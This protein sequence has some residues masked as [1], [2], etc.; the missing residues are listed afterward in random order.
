MKEKKFDLSKKRNRKFLTYQSLIHTE[1]T[2]ISFTALTNY[3]SSLPL[4]VKKQYK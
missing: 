1:L 4:E 3:H 2:K